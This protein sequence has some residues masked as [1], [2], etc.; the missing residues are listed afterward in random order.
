MSTCAL[1]STGRRLAQ[2]RWD[3]RGGGTARHLRGAG[4]ADGRIPR[5]RWHV[6]RI[7]PSIRVVARPAFHRRDCLDGNHRCRGEGDAAL[8]R[9]TRRADLADVGCNHRVA[10]PPGEGGTY[11]PD[12]RE[13]RPASGHAAQQCACAGPGGRVLRAPCRATRRHDGE[14]PARTAQSIR[15]ISRRPSLDDERTPRAGQPLNKKRRSTPESRA[16]FFVPVTATC[17][18][19]PA[20][21]REPGRHLSG[22]GPGTRSRRSPRWRVLP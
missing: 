8:T 22:R 1:G 19:W 7:Q 21:R 13:C 20:G 10:Q 5:V 15:G 4:A 14:V 6:H 16:A 12:P 2:E 3:H 18:A 11:R 17:R 9:P